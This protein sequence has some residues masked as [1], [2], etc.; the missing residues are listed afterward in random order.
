[1]LE[2][3]IQGRGGQGAQTAGNLLAQAF[4]REGKE[5]QSVASYGGAR[6][7]TPVTSMI[8]VDDKP[9]RLRCDVERADAILCFDPTLLDARLLAR[10]DRD[11]VI[12]VNAGRATWPN[13]GHRRIYPIEAVR[14]SQ[15]HNLGRVV[16]SALLGAFC[17]LLGTP[18]LETMC[19][20]VFEY[21]PLK[22]DDNVAACRA[23]CEAAD[24]RFIEGRALCER[25]AR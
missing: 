8:R 23:G 25:S 2:I 12:L 19:A 20:T 5:V 3:I 16:N 6:R 17:S 18:A 14:I 22:R 24:L 13:P 4:F 1:M 9:I 7:G 10:A 15:E 11:T 21:A